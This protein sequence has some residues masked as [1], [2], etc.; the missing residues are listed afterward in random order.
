MAKLYL[1][2]TSRDN[3]LVTKLSKGLEEGG[4]I[5][6]AGPGT[7]IPGTNWQQELDNA[8]K[9]ADGM[10]VFYTQNTFSSQS[11]L[12]EIGSARAYIKAF[13]NKFLI[14]VVFGDIEIPV[15]LRDLLVLRT[16][17]S[18]FDISIQQINTS[19][20]N[21]M[22]KFAADENKKKEVISK[23]ETHSTDYILQTIESLS[24][25]ERS[26]KIYASICYVLGY[27]TLLLSALYCFVRPLTPQ[28]AKMSDYLFFGIR[29]LVV[30]GLLIACSKYTFSL[31]KAYMNESLKNADRIHAISFGRFYLKTFGDQISFSEVKEIFQHW[32]VDKNSYFT[33]LEASQFDPKFIDSI[34]ELG[35]LVSKKK[36]GLEQ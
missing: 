21:I 14:P 15:M 36:E 29:S 9:S 20:N 30:I 6:V 28:G 34:V 10:I 4:N 35:K 11:V 32:N 5:I 12:A 25:R 33:S 22:A 8:L 1:S 27:A 23:I 16:N 31:G 17:E 18:N 13:N 7:L 19:I 3:E 26:N 2:Y 24:K